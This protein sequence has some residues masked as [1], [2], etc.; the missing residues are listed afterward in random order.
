MAA[1]EALSK[2]EE[3]VRTAVAS[4]MDEAEKAAEATRTALQ[5]AEAASRLAA[6]SAKDAAAKAVEAAKGSP[7]K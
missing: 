5:K 4:S 1:K 2:A 6:Q 7:G 3:A